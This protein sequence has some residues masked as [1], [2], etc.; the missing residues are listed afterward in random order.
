VT[1]AG[2][3]ATDDTLSVLLPS[4]DETTLLEACLHTGPRAA[5]AWDRWRARR[6]PSGTSVCHHLATARTLLPLLA[7]SAARNRLD[8]GADVLAY[9]RAAALREELRSAGFRRLTA[10]ALTALGASATSAYVVRGA[11]LAATVYDSWSLRHCHDLDLLVP[12][13]DLARAIRA[14]SSVEFRVFSTGGVETG[15]RLRHPS[16]LDVAV[17]TRAFAV[18]YYDAPLEA[19]A[20]PGQVVAIEGVPARILQPEAMLVHVLG[21]ATYSPSRGNL[22]WVSDA[23]HVVAAHE[24]LDWS[25]VTARIAAYRLA[26][27]V[28]TLVGYLSALGARVPSEVAAKLRSMAAGADRAAEDVALGGVHAATGSDTGRLW[29]ATMSWRGR[30]RIIRWAVAPSRRYMRS[31]FSASRAWLYPIYY[32]YRPVRFLVGWFKR[33]AIALP[34]ARA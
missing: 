13:V 16:G 34:R 7:R 18:A 24:D 21:H 33:R 9:V 17:H 12:A 28:A 10:Q 5:E 19:L 29:S 6:G 26:V 14:L 4:P 1:A 11:A 22:R 23:W 25:D 2:V 20:A 15:T 27:P 3:R 8:L 31:A 32:V 30:M